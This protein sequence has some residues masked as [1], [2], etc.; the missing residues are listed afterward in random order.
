MDEL[1]FDNFERLHLL[2]AVPALAAVVW[3]GFWRKRRDLAGFATLNLV[4]TLTSGVSRGKQFVKAALVLA[5]LICLVAAAIGPRWGY[6]YEEVQ[7]KGIDIMVALDVS[8][9][10]LARDV[11]PSRLER[12]KQDI[13]DLLSALGGDRIGLLTFAGTATLTCPLTTDYSFFRLA[14]DEVDTRSASRGGTRLGDAVTKAISCFDDRIQKYKAIVVISDGE[15]HDSDAV[16]AA[17]AAVEEHGIKVFTIGLGDA[18]EGR[19]IPI[20][21]DGQDVYLVHDGQEVWSKLNSRLLEAM[22]RAGGGAYVPAGTASIDLDRIYNRYIG[23]QQKR[24]FGANR[25]KRYYARYQWFAGAAL[26]LIVFSGVLSERRSAARGGRGRALEAIGYD[27][28]V[29]TGG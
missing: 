1:R 22:A 7:Q 24:E 5:G 4:G 17:R 2:W 23:P 11:V 28:D 8:R 3:Y 16:A 20:T 25:V 14:L 9:S 15:D 6:E 27:W 12:A 21:R 10:M 19:R 13:R 18:A 29:Q 26:V